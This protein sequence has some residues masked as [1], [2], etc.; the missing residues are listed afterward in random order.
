SYISSC[1]KQNIRST[2]ALALLFKGE[3]PEFVN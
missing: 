3:M 1:R 2:T